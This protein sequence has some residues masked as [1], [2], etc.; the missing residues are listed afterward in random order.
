MHTPGESYVDL[1]TCLQEAA[2]L[3]SPAVPL[4]VKADPLHE[5]INKLERKI[6]G[7]D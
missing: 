4:K 7:G 3:S 6:V 1:L 5:A 2:W